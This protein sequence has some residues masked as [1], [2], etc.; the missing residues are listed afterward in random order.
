[1]GRHTVE[2]DPLERFESEHDEAL[3]ALNRL[4]L[5]TDALE[6]AERPEQFLATVREV[7]T[8]L[9]T[10]VREHNDNEEWAL[11]GLLGEDAPVALFE[12]EHRTLRQ[13]ERNLAAALDGSD[14]A[15]EVP[16]PA[17]AV[18]DLLRAHIERENEVLFP[19]ARTLLGP[20]G[21]ETVARRLA[22]PGRAG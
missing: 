19:M 11:F 17:R 2:P 5:A 7:H 1:M 21:I 12:E 18:I 3:R 13:L 20:E 6:H 8:F 14:P 4:E 9:T 16:S 15:R 10:V 22:Q